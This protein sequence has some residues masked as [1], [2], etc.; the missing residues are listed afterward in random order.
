MGGDYGLHFSSGDEEIADLF[1]DIGL[2]RNSARV[3]TILIKD[4]DLTSREIERITDLRQPEVS[5]AITDLMK[6]KWI[7]IVHQITENKGRPMKVY[8]L[9]KNLDDILDELKESIVGSYEKKFGEI[10]RVRELLQS[11]RMR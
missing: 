11:T 7:H 10:E 9:G 6:R 4:I 1:W 8:H 3:L 5:I 2:K